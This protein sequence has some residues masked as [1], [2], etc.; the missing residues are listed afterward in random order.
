M[1]DVPRKPRADVGQ[2]HRAA[3][4]LAD[5]GLL[6]VDLG[7]QRLRVGP[8]RDRVAVAA[9]GR[10]QLVVGAERGER[11]DD[12][13]LRAVREVRVPADHA[14]V[15]LERALH[16]LLELADPHHLRVHPRRAVPSRGRSQTL[17][18]LSLASGELR[19]WSSR[20]RGRRSARSGGCAA[21]RTA[22]RRPR[23]RRSRARGRRRRS[24]GSGTRPRPAACGG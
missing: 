14:R 22:P 16:A 24:P 5:P 11:A 15:L 23:G 13:R 4:A 3:V 18:L 12:R 1:P 7:H 2:V 19:R 6:A 8:E 10:R 20:R 17:R 21:P 9:V